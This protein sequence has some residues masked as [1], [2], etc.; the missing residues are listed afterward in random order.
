[1]AEKI[2]VTV[3]DEEKEFSAEDV[4]GLLQKIEELEGTAS[5]VKPVLQMADRYGVDMQTLVRQSEGSMALVSKLLDEGVINEKGEV[6]LEPKQESRTE[7]RSNPQQSRLPWEKD[8][9]SGQDALS[10]GEEKILEIVQRALGNTL[11][12]VEERLKDLEGDI[13]SMT[14]ERLRNKL[15]EQHPDL[16]DF[17]IKQLFSQAMSDRSKSLWDH[18]AEFSKYK[19]SKLDELRKKHAEEFGVNL[20]E[21]ERNKLKQQDGSKG[22]ATVV[23]GKSISFKKGSE[24]TVT[25]MQ[26][27]LEYMKNVEEGG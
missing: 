27:T 24:N 26:A 19:Q 4:G 12:P 6:V 1:M 18:A 23:Q 11:K 7:P 21:V 9:K 15:K 5:K 17:E 3:G 22:P 16:E 10:V 14:E 25:P 2:K 13:T 20:E 8:A